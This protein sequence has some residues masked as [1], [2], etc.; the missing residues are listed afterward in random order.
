[1]QGRENKVKHSLWVLPSG[2]KEKKADWGRELGNSAMEKGKEGHSG[3]SVKTEGTKGRSTGVINKFPGMK[4]NSEIHTSKEHGETGGQ[5]KLC[6]GKRQIQLP[7][8][9]VAGT[10][11]WIGG[12]SGSCPKMD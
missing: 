5:E 8:A 4:W 1:V 11:G 6:K 10:N 9:V 2:L 3:A 12:G 7:L